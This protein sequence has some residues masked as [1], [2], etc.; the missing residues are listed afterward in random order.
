MAGKAKRM[1]YWTY[2]SFDN[3][4]TA[5]ENRCKGEKI[6]TCFEE[7]GYYRKTVTNLGGVLGVISYSNSVPSCAY[8]S[9]VDKKKNV[10]RMRLQ[11]AQMDW[12]DEH[13]LAAVRLF[14]DKEYKEL[15]A[16]L[17]DLTERYGYS[18][19]IN[20][21]ARL[22]LSQDFSI[23]WSGGNVNGTFWLE[24]R[25]GN[26]II[27]CYVNFRSNSLFWDREDQAAMLEYLR[28]H[29]GRFLNVYIGVPN[30]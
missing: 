7:R 30:R 6:W 29:G 15:I 21:L 18:I 11:M 4:L 25:T 3:P 26:T 22:N 2:R 12:N 28:D 19:H 13:V 20:D 9:D 8:C 24:D 16:E 23:N 14:R 5:G 10:K 1:G 27:S 17:P